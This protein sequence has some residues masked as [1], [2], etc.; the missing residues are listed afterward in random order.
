MTEDNTNSILE[1]L[2][3]ALRNMSYAIRRLD[4]AGMFET[5][6]YLGHAFQRISAVHTV[7][8]DTQDTDDD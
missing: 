8:T 2:T 5:A 3:R 6:D 7:L 4:D 1:D